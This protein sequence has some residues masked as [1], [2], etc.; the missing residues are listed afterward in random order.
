M[1][2]ASF[3][4]V[5]DRD[6]CLISFMPLIRSIFLTHQNETKNDFTEILQQNPREIKTEKVKIYTEI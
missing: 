5:N 2:N 4:A 6:F 3:G 1:V